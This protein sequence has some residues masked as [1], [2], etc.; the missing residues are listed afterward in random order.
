M[1]KSDTVLAALLTGKEETDHKLRQAFELGIR[2]GT[3][4]DRKNI[5]TFTRIDQ[6]TRLL[7]ALMRTQHIDL[8]QALGIFSIPQKERD[9]YR[10]IISKRQP[11]QTKTVAANDS[12]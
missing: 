3:A 9:T 4:I 11:K 12:K 8:E 6:T 7:V 5:Q 1:S 2:H 10:R